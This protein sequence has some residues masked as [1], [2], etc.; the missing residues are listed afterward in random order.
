MLKI[1]RCIGRMGKVYNLLSIED[2]EK[3]LFP[4]I[5]IMSFSDMLRNIPFHYLK[6]LSILLIDYLDF[7]FYSWH[8][9]RWKG[10]SGFLEIELGLLGKLLNLWMKISTCLV[11]NWPEIIGF[12]I[13][14]SF[15][16]LS[17]WLTGKRILRNLI[18]LLLPPLFKH[19][20]PIRP[21]LLV[22]LK[23]RKIWIL[24]V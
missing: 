9:L 24:T 18:L 3:L 23:I 6:V 8:L 17:L 1:K 10:R 5:E 2:S 15:R 21:L 12:L 4:F 14:I 13:R 11:Q 22:H 20:L 16:L 19:L 7:A